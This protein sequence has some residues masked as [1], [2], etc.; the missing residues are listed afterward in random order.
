MFFDEMISVGELIL[1]QSLNVVDI[2]RWKPFWMSWVIWWRCFNALWKYDVYFLFY[3]LVWWAWF[4]SHVAKRPNGKTTRRRET[5]RTCCFRSARSVLFD[6]LDL[7]KQHIE[8]SSSDTLSNLLCNKVEL[9][10]FPQ[11]VQGSVLLRVEH[12]SYRSLLTSVGG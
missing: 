1:W 3:V 6:L 2:K 7:L 8:Q 5:W 4:S 11:N 9:I 10:F 12:M